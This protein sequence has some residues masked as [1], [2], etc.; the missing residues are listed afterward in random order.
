MQAP[1]FDAIILD[2]ADNVA[3]VL[4]A[5]PP[6]ET[7]RIRLGQEERALAVLEAVPLCHKVALIDI[8]TGEP[9]TK[10]GE[11][12]GRAVADIR[13]GRLVHVHNMRTARGRAA[14]TPDQR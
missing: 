9:V 1:L 11:P 2:P 13:A 5:L 7:A 10:Y 8:R 6:G 4:R 14:A 3:T 12:I